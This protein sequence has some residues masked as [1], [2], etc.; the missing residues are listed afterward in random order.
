MHTLDD[1]TILSSQ[2]FLLVHGASGRT[3][4]MAKCLQRLSLLHALSSLTYLDLHLHSSPVVVGV[5][6]VG[7]VDNGD[8]V[9]LAQRCAHG[10]VQDR[11]S[12]TII[13]HQATAI[14]CAAKCALAAVF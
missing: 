8:V 13:S 7:C 12:V 14:P 2:H 3:V 9:K 4:V 10:S 6:V 11:H 1:L 5:V